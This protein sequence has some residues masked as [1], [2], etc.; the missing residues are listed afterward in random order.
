MILPESQFARIESKVATIQE[1][2]DRGLAEPGFD[3][4]KALDALRDA[5]TALFD[6][7][8]TLL[9]CIEIETPGRAPDRPPAA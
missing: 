3:R 9:D 4:Q 2:I 6:L 5:R 8:S 7:R 1:K